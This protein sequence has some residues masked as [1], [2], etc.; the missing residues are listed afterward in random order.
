M[1]LKFAIYHSAAKSLFTGFLSKCVQCGVKNDWPSYRHLFKHSVNKA[2]F[3]CL[4]SMHISNSLNSDFEYAL[5]L[6]IRIR[7]ITG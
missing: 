7:I 6:R 2:S 4:S 1:L 5:S 3:P